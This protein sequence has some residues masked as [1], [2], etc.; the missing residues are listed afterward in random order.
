[1]CLDFAALCWVLATNSSAQ[2][3][4]VE[5]RHGQVEKTRAG[6]G[7]LQSRDLIDASYAT[8]VPGGPTGQYVIL[9]YRSTF[10]NRPDEAVET[11]TLA[12]AKGYWRVS[13]YYIK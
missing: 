12:F 3:P 13:G 6:T 5:S 11:L 4:P 1:M 7:A 8:T 9:H 2:I 10:A